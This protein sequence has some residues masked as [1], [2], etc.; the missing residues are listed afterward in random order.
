M[1]SAFDQIPA[2]L[3]SFTHFCIFAVCICHVVKAKDAC[4]S[5]RQ[6]DWVYISIYLQLPAFEDSEFTWRL[7]TKAHWKLKLLV[8]LTLPSIP[9]LSMGNNHVNTIQCLKGCRTP[10]SDTNRHSLIWSIKSSHC[11][12]QLW[13]STWMGG[14]EYWAYCS[15]PSHLLPSYLRQTLHFAELD[16]IPQPED[17]TETE[18]YLWVNIRPPEGPWPQIYTQTALHGWVHTYFLHFSQ[19]Y[20]LSPVGI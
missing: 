9:F 7:E 20:M 18:I 1:I 14:F 11:F 2:S 3:L 4:I 12:D 13:S 8:F 10:T 19:L 5:P 17:G 16:P 6:T 15:L